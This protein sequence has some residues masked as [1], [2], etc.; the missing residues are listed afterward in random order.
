MKPLA[1]WPEEERRRIRGVLTDIDDT[2]TT[3]GRL[4]PEVLAALGRLRDAGLLVIAVTGRPTY[5]AMPLLKLCGFDAVIA[6]NGASAFWLDEGGGLDSWFYADEAV[7][8]EHRR[9]LE[10]FVPVLRQRFPGIPV[11]DDAPMRIGDLAFDIGENVSPL[12]AGE[13]GEVVEFIRRH[14]FFA[15]ASSIHAHASLVKFC[16]Q[17]TSEIILEQIFHVDDALAR[18]TF[19]F[20]GDSGNDA[21]MFGHYPHAIGVANIA[22]HLGKMDSAPS[23]VTNA[24]YGAGFVEV[25]DAIL[26]ARY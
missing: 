16:K 21:R 2:L 17:K 6:E 1:Q 12:V 7:R 18:D 10:A 5:W 20:V 4:T 26:A 3:H 24:S 22:A 9:K 15:A 8:M 25:A 19:A 13:V 23:Y 14:G 11:A